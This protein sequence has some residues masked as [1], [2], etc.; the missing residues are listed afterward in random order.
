LLPPGPPKRELRRLRLAFQKSP[1]RVLKQ[2]ALEYGSVSCLDLDN[3]LVVLLNDPEYVKT[4]LVSS[5]QDFGK[6]PGVDLMKQLVGEGVLTSE[7]DY[8]TWQRRL[9]QSSF[10]HEAVNSYADFMVQYSEV[11]MKRWER[12]YRA[13]VIVDIHSEMVRLTR[14]IV[15]KSLFGVDIGPSE[16]VNWRGSGR[17]KLEEKILLPFQDFIDWL[18]PSR[19]LPDSG[20]KNLDKLIER[21]LSSYQA[22]LPKGNLLS[23]LMEARDPK[24][25][26]S[27]SDKQIRDEVATMLIAGHFTTANALAWMWYL[28][29]NNPA[30]ESK[31]HR[32]LVEVLQGRP[33]SISDLKSL[34]YTKCVFDEVLRLYPSVWLIAR[35]SRGPCSIGGYSIPSGST[36]LISPYITHR[37]QRYFSDPNDFVPDRWSP[38]NRDSVK[39]FA[40]FPFGSG[41]RSCI[42][43][44]FAYLEGLLVLATVAQSYQMRL[45][46]G[47][48]IICDPRPFELLDPKY[49]I[50]M[51]LEKRSA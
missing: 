49:G 48:P 1:L 44:H 16:D 50:M 51:S 5:N 11:M 25:G 4:V 35:G 20:K 34:V 47:Y 9:M 26:S 23:S 15:I 14:D 42:G 21:I 19:H 45:V 46:D 3:R 31:L 12:G 30:V 2:L 10:S 36:I 27:M 22:T 6:A 43:E 33:P 41:P 8:H 18:Q 29:A 32:E 28:L 7:G 40:Y 37:D 39:K 13:G 17:V 38:E 24:S